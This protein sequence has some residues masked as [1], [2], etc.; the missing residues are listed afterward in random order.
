M[1]NLGKP[2]AFGQWLRSALVQRYNSTRISRRLGSVRMAF[3]RSL[4]ALS[5]SAMLLASGL[6]ASLPAAAGVYCRD[7]PNFHF[8][9]P[10]KFCMRTDIYMSAI[11]R[12]EPDTPMVFRGFLQQVK[13]SGLTPHSVT[14]HSPGGSIA[15]AMDWG[16]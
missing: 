10:M 9:A 8:Q 13:R 6:V 7:A 12:L 16:E 11:G 3:L 5:A 2:F 4:A 14:F 15:G 1:G